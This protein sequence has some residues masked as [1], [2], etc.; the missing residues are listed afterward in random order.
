MKDLSI[1]IGRWSLYSQQEEPCYQPV[2]LLDE[3]WK[4]ICS[5]VI[6]NGVD[7]MGWQ[8]K[9]DRNM[10]QECNVYFVRKLRLTDT[11]EWMILQHW[12]NS[13]LPEGKKRRILSKGKCPHC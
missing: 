8:K 2:T 4:H 6:R 3:F 11:V 13:D 10:G 12:N 1:M 7:K 9:A 5:N